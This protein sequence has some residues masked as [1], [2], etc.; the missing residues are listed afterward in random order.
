LCI[1]IVAVALAT[2]GIKV[3]ADVIASF[4]VAEPDKTVNVNRGEI[5]DST[6]T[7]TVADPDAAVGYIVKAKLSADIATNFTV[8]IWSDDSTFCS[9]ASKCTLT[10]ADKL[11]YRNTTDSATIEPG[12]AITFNVRISASVSTAMTQHDIYIDYSKENM[13]TMQTFECS[14]LNPYVTDGSEL[15][16]MDKRD[17]KFYRVRKLTDGKCWM[18]DNLALAGS[19]TLD[20]ISSDIN[21]GTY[22][23][24]AVG[25]PNTVAYCDLL[26]VAIYQQKCGYHY[27]W[28]QATIDSTLA[29]G[30]AQD[31][32]CPKN[33]RL[34]INGEYATLQSNLGWGNAG[35]NVIGSAWRGLYAGMDTSTNVNVTGYY[36]TSTAYSA[37]DAYR[38]H[39]N[40]SS[41]RPSY[42]IGKTVQFSVRCLAK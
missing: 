25:D 28:S 37:S 24:G 36:W 40:A 33:W 30:S 19:Q 31:S 2:G 23:L 10:T 15:D 35:I 32:I 41:V 4:A 29:S 22:D 16:L 27:S 9:E 26:D 13:P 17:K 7:V 1:A 18:V 39:F 6:S 38:L 20:D 11:V 12:D 34:P 5:V 8:Q 14:S 3:L 21:S 42:N